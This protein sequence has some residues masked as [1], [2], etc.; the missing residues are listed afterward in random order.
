[1]NGDLRVALAV[2]RAE[3]RDQRYQAT[4]TRRKRALL[5]VGGVALLPVAAVILILAHAA[6]EAAASGDLAALPHVA[7]WWLPIVFG[8]AALNSAVALASGLTS[9]G[10]RDL[11]LSTVPDRTLA[12]GLL[13]N[14]LA[15]AALVSGLPAVGVYGAFALGAGSPT[16]AVVGTAALTLVL[17]A[18]AL[19]GIAVGVAARVALLEVPLSSDARDLYG[20]VAKGGLMV[21][22]GAAGAVGG[23][24]LGDVEDSALG[25]SML[26][27]SGPAPVPGHA[28][29]L[30]FVGTPLVDGVGATAAASAVGVAVVAVASTAAILELVPRLWYADPAKPDPESDPAAGRTS[31]AADAA[32]GAATADPHATESRDTG[33]PPADAVAHP[34]SLLDG[35]RL[36][37]AGRF[38]VVLDALLRRTARQPT[39]LAHV[40]YYVFVPVVVGVSLLTVGAPV[41]TAVGLAF[42]VLGLW[43]AGG[44]FCLNPLGEEGTMLG[45]VVLGDVPARTHVRAR[46][47]AGTAL[48]APLVLVGTALLAVETL[49][50]R[51]A[52]ALGAYWL[53]LVPASAGLA[54]GLGTLLPNAE[55]RTVLDAV[56]TRAPELL[57]IVFHALLVAALADAGR[58]A[59]GAAL[60]PPVAAGVAAT[61]AAVLV[62]VGH[63]GYR[64]AVGGLADYGRPRT[65]DPVFAVEL[66]AGLALT[67]LV[68]SNAAGLGVAILVD[69]EGFAGF[70]VD[71]LGQYAGWATAVAAYP[72]VTGRTDFLDVSWPTRADLRTGIAGLAALAGVWALAVGATELLGLPLARHSLDETLSGGG[73]AVV[74]TLVVL[75][76][77]VVGPVEELLFRNVVQKRLGEAL[78]PLA[79]VAVASG[80]FALVHLPAYATGGAAAVAAA[81]ALLAVLGAVLGVVYERTDTVVVPALCHGCYNAALFVLA[82]AIA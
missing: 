61:L 22:F 52:L 70:I 72:L 1:M 79:A 59:T 54:L 69:A 49:P 10:A 51:R 14:L 19:F 33:A 18:S 68:L 30:L 62:V 45:Q 81:L 64:F 65:P 46:L 67:G 6:G 77:A 60:S 13:A 24:A 73:V 9:F 39:R 71:F 7:R 11:L 15:G 53:A 78:D 3:R 80:L 37:S 36:P 48:G 2:V 17:L 50:P 66:A 57:A 26:A 82:F 28:A 8:M 27:P 29:D 38:G 21:G 47:A 25:L 5:L 35:G 40:I 43:L 23:A 32:D 16:T 31:G 75:S 41:P 56:E 58:R 34:P 12:A 4:A 76:L 42:V 74:A 63:G 55:T 20:T 44:V